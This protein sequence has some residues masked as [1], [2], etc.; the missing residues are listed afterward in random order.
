[1]SDTT[2]NYKDLIPDDISDYIDSFIREEEFIKKV[3]T[4]YLIDMQ[5]PINQYTEHSLQ[6]TL[7][8]DL[9]S[10]IQKVLNEFLQEQEISQELQEQIKIEIPK[11]I[12]KD[13]T[14]LE[15]LPKILQEHLEVNLLEH[16]QTNIQS[17]SMPI[18]YMKQTI[19][20][21]TKDFIQGFI[22]GMFL[23]HIKYLIIDFCKQ[24]QSETNE[25]VK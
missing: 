20:K 5:E 12:K 7:K 13:L 17:Y 3:I 8:E 16:I 25:S 14:T 1:M 10:L 2:K 23:V 19:P 24:N 22:H 15:Q 18:L 9:Q 4:N 6:K 21:Y 11:E